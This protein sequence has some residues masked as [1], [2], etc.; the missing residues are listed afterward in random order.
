MAPTQFPAEVTRWK[1]LW[2]RRGRA[3]STI[4]QYVREV[5]R[6][7]E[8]YPEN[9][10]KSASLEAA[11]DYVASVEDRSI[12]M[13]RM[14]GRAIKA[15]G[16][17][18]SEDYGEGDPFKRLLLPKEPEP[19][20]APTATEVDLD[21]LLAVCVPELARPG[22]AKSWDHLRDRAIILVLADS[23]IRRGEVASMML[24][25]LDLVEGS[26]KLWDT[27]NSTSRTVYLTERVVGALLRYLRASD[28][29]R[30]EGVGSVWLSVHT[31]PHGA[32]TPSGI[33]QM[34]AK[35]GKAGD[36]DVRAHAFRR[37]HAGLW[38]ARGGSETGL[39]TNS[40]WK[41]S[42]MISRYTKDT[43]ETSARDE[44]RRLFG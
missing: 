36:V 11:D 27:K 7:I 41:T 34:L 2:A 4:E 38:M 14:A 43:K 12:H 17:Y 31:R 15:Y 26:V 30:A 16:K 33:G 1:R 25:D 13:A 6:F 42:A 19:R 23:G 18:L 10:H 21:K 39:K 37:M 20:N 32:L 24:D 5:E 40:G 8:W 35:R 9:G 44:A 29:Y 28:G 3:E 22:F